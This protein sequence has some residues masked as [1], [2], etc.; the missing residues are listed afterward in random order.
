MFF[1]N[2]RGVSLLEVMIA[3]GALGILSAM[4]M[5]IVRL[6]GKS[7]AKLAQDSDV[8]YTV[9]E[10]YALL[11]DP[12]RCIKTFGPTAAGGNGVNPTSII[13]QVEVTSGGDPT[14]PNDITVLSEKFFSEEDN[15]N[16]DSKIGNAKLQ[17]KSYRLAG[18]VGESTLTIT[19][20]KKRILENDPNSDEKEEFTRMINMYT[21]SSTA[22][23]GNMTLCRSLASADTDIWS[24][25]EGSKIFYSAGNVG[26]DV[27][28][29][30]FKLHVDG[31]V[32][33]TETVTASS[34]LYDSDKNLKENIEPIEDPLDKI[35]SLQGVTFDWRKN[36]KHDFGFIAQEVRDLIPEIVRKDRSRDTLTVDYAKIIPFLVEAI[37][38]Q[39]EEIF[40]LKKEINSLK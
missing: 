19:F 14:N 31:E 3:A 1:K 16:S 7:T 2:N 30:L 22:S 15:A 5:G 13:S 21:E 17:I 39:Q 11:S 8:T 25:G 18:G 34:F 26:I 12:K 20:Y 10:I 33:T 37:K 23:L 38:I 4:V 9:N 40:E 27:E 24:R 36:G 35:M 28:D 6:S 32:V 29:P